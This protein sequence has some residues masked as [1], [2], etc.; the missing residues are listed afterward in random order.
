M[1]L[2]EIKGELKGYD[3]SAPK[4]D[5]LQFIHRLRKK[6]GQSRKV[7]I[8]RI[9]EVRKINQVERKKRAWVITI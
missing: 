7:V 8:R 1:P 3:E 2:V 4:I 5:E 9:Q 6:Y